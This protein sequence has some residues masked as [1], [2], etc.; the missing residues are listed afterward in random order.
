M[1]TWIVTGA[2]GF[3]GERIS[4]YWSSDSG[5]RVIG[6][7]HAEMDFTDPDVVKRVFDSVRPDVL[8]HAGAIADTGVCEREPE[9]SMKVNVWGT[10]I[11]AQTC[12][13]YHTKMIYCSSDQVYTGSRNILPHTED[14]P[15]Q[16]ENIYGQHKRMAEVLCREI[17]PDSVSL[18]LSWMYD[19]PTTNC[20]VK[21]NF[22]TQL[23][24]QI[25][26]KEIFSRPV[27]DY[28]G[29]TDAAYVVRFLDAC[30]AFPGG[31]YNWGSENPLNTYE[32]TKEVLKLL[33]ADTGLL[34][35]D[36]ERDQECP[37]NLAM[38]MKKVRHLGINFPDTV[39][40]IEKCLKKYSMIV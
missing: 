25:G 26:R 8:I 22:L 24:E 28:R 20:P 19:L 33:H 21:P 2:G 16:P 39:T 3:L 32:M 12:A 10:E 23:L 15:V 31:I 37:R 4:A 5:K 7:T 40:G 1:E 13:A 18:R 6:M 29:I 27:N 11:L 9:L 14:E 38:N 17:S 34:L 35:A 30:T 36:T